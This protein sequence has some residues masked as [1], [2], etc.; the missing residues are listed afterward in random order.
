MG[1]LEAR[2]FSWIETTRRERWGNKS[3][4]VKM[5][6]AELKK[7]GIELS[8]AIPL[9]RLGQVDYGTA[10]ATYLPRPLRLSPLERVRNAVMDL[11][12]RATGFIPHS[13]AQTTNGARD[14]SIPVNE[15]G[16]K[17]PKENVVEV[18]AAPRDK[19]QKPKKTGTS[20]DA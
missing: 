6:P 7:L 1:F 16:S 15:R 17:S 11:K 19:A 18:K 4:L 5:K 8:S 13:I 14:G 2:I 20:R 9:E 10:T 3:P 12:L